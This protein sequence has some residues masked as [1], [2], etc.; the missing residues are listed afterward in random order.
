MR[1]VDGR[2]VDDA[3]RERLVGVDA[4]IEVVAE[5]GRD[6]RQVVRRRLHRREP[7]RPLDAVLAGGESFLREQRRRVAVLRGAPGMKRLAHR[8]EHLAQPGGLRRG[9]A[10]RPD[11]LLHRQ[12][13]QPADRRRGAEH[14]GRAGDVPAGVVVRG[15][16]GVAD[17]RL[18][19]EAEDERVDEVAAA[20]AG[21]R[22]HTRTA[23]RRPASVGW[24]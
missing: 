19:F 5:A 9:E 6:L 23:P 24:L 7:A 21:S 22:S 4:Q 3:A 2:M 13:H 16:D 1:A 15:I 8:A 20:D 11:H 14:A 17:A 18:G 12:A 10:D